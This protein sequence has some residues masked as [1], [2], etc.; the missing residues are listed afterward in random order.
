MTEEMVE[1][2]DVYGAYPRLSEH[3][4]QA[5]SKSG[6]RRHVERGDLLYR[7]GDRGMDFVVVLQGLVAVIEGP[8]RLSAFMAEGVFSASSTSYR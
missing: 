7:Q 8:I 3:Q 5:I 4:I 6:T 1:T 2:P